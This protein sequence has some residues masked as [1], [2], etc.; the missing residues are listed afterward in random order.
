MKIAL[1]GV[2]V[3]SGGLVAVLRDVL[4]YTPPIEYKLSIRLYCSEEFSKQYSQISK[5]IEVYVCKSLIDTKLS[6]TITTKFSND[7]IKEI[8]AYNPDAVFYLT[9]TYRKGLEKYCS[10]F[11]LNNQLLTNY[12]R[13]F[14]QKSAKVIIQLLLMAVQFRINIKNINY[15]FFSSKYSE[16]ETKKV[17]KKINSYIVPFACNSIFFKDA[18]LSYKEINKNEFIILYVSSIIPYKNQKA[19]IEAMKILKTKGYFPKL[20]LVG[21]VVSRRYYKECVSLITKYSLEANVRFTSWV[22]YDNI[23]ALIDKADIFLNASETDTCGT[24]VQEGMARGL[25]IAAN[26]EKFNRE[27][28]GNSGQ[29]F[30]V[31]KPN[32]IANAI[33]RYV[34]D[35]DFRNRNKKQAFELSRRWT[36]KDTAN[37][38]FKVIIQ[39]AYGK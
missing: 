4:D 2:G 26:D 29:Y 24:L 25:A 19:V 38:Y 23:P 17:I 8:E 11:V 15:I 12:P 18:K 6:H 10:Y 39:S 5:C 22:A 36:L 16:E 28:L 21:R 35:D 34:I 14:R 31:K 1:L 9:G 33:E 3:S 13:I 7:F 30:D 32:S 27:M 37:E 20:F